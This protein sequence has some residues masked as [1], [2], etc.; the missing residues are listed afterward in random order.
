MAKHRHDHSPSQAS[1]L[2]GADALCAA[3]GAKLDG[4]RRLVLEALHGSNKALGAYDLIE[5]V[6]VDGTKRPAPVQIYR[7]LDFLI[8]HGLVHRIESRNAFVACPHHHASHETVVFFLCDSCGRV[9]EEASK[10]MK[11]SL[12]ALAKKQGFN[13]L[14]NIVEVGGR[15][16]GCGESAMTA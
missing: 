14:S 13:P 10:S 2:A 5:A 1:G 7:A 16:S 4:M 8:E 9:Q 15:C 6:A 12:A 11:S 3:K